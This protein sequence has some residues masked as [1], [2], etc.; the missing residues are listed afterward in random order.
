M[1]RKGRPTKAEALERA[2]AIIRDMGADGGHAFDIKA[3][4]VAIACDPKVA[5]TARISAA[6][7]WREIQ[8]A[9]A[10]DAAFD[11]A[12]LSEV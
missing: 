6:R 12:G 11:A 8:I 3:V 2:W 10:N 4:L 1:A 9:E 7:L 5:P